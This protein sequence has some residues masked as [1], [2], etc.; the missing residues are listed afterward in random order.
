MCLSCCECEALRSEAGEELSF[1]KSK[2]HR[3]GEVGVP[4]ARS[5]ASEVEGLRESA[6]GPAPEGR[7]QSEGRVLAREREGGREREEEERQKEELSSMQ[8]KDSLF[9]TLG[10][11]F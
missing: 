5:S 9:T 3:R 10:K 1:N 6:K 4:Q 2:R 11:S 7:E 8:K